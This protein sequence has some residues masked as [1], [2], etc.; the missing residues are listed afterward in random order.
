MAAKNA[1]SPRTLGAAGC[2][3]RALNG[4]IANNDNFATAIN[5]APA[6]LE[7]RRNC[8]TCDYFQFIGPSAGR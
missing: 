2:C 4:F 3:F 1:G 6:P 5:P 8:L 7:R